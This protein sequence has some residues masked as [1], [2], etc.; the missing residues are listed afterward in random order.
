MMKQGIISEASASLAT[1][2]NGG[3]LQQLRQARNALTA[4]TQGLIRTIGRRLFEK[5]KG[6][7]AMTSNRALVEIIKSVKGRSHN[8]SIEKAAD[9]IKVF[10]AEH[11]GYRYL[12]HSLFGASGTSRQRTDY[13]SIPLAQRVANVKR[14]RRAKCVSEN[15]RQTESQWVG[16]K[17]SITIRTSTESFAEGITE[18]VWH[19]KKVRSGTNSFL[20]VAFSPTWYTDVYKK[21]IAVV[22]GMVTTHASELAPGVWH[23]SWVEQGRGFSLRA[24][25]GYIVVVDGTAAH[26]ATESAARQSLHRRSPAYRESHEARFRTLRERLERGDAGDYAEVAVTFAD[27]LRAGNCET[28][29]THWSNKHFPGRETATICEIL[30]IDDEKRLSIAACLQAIRR[31]RRQR[32]S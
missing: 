3:K 14:A 4:N 2:A 9:L 21:G 8:I 27:S 19:D 32:L 28:G 16:G 29:T 7:F 25:T 31:S 15:Y 30:A 20:T 13:W 23:A 6:L 24:V 10:I 26:G 1:S 18:K 17:R 12:K 11:A 5:I 22:S